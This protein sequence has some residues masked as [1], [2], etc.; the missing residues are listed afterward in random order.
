MKPGSNNSAA[1]DIAAEL[2]NGL[3]FDSVVFMY[4]ENS[5]GVI[6][7]LCLGY[8]IRIFVERLLNKAPITSQSLEDMDEEW[9]D[10]KRRVDATFGTKKSTSIRSGKKPE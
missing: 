5:I 10:L 9:E 2:D 3:G 6:V 7:G 1:R 4:I 8:A